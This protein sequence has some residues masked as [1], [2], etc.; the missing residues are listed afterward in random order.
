MT[1]QRFI[2]TICMAAILTAAWLPLG[3][4]DEHQAGGGCTSG[5]S[6]ILHATDR[7]VAVAY[8]GRK[9]TDS[10][11]YLRSDLSLPCIVSLQ[12]DC[13]HDLLWIPASDA[14]DTLR[15]PSART[16]FTLHC[17]LTV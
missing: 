17:L 11:R 5:L 15:A 8:A 2:A 13:S 3:T 12:H 6:Q 14:N 10:V 9:P 4:A 1:I 7:Y 16:L